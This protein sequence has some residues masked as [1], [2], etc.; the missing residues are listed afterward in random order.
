LAEGSVGTNCPR[1]LLNGRCAHE[2][3][4]GRLSR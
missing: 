4:I 3:W 2:G 1:R